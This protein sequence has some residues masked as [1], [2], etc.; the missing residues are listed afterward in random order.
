MKETMN[1]T[2]RA[3]LATALGLP[4][5]RRMASHDDR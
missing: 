2:K 3:R 5:E 4:Q 1:E